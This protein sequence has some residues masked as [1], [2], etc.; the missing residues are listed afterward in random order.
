MCVTSG[1]AS[2]KSGDSLRLP[3]AEQTADDITIAI[4]EGDDFVAFDLLVAAEPMLSP[5][6]F[7]AVVVPSPWMTVASRRLA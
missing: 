4:A 6:F 3:G 1:R 5:P 7:A 2:R